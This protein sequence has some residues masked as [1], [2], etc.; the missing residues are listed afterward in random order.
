MSRSICEP[1]ADSAF[2][3]DIGAFNIIYA[4]PNAIGISEIEFAQITV[5]VAVA[6]VLVDALHATLENAVTV[7]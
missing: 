5:Q 4:K 7:C 3:R 6:T 2:Q 1:L